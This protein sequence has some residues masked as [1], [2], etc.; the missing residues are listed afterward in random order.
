VR[1][2]FA[3]DQKERGGGEQGEEVERVSM[4]G[5]AERQF[6]THKARS[7]FLSLSLCIPHSAGLC[8]PT[9]TKQEQTKGGEW[10]SPL[11]CLF[12]LRCFNGQ[13]KIT[14]HLCWSFASHQ[15]IV[16]GQ[17]SSHTPNSLPQFGHPK[18]LSRHVQHQSTNKEQTDGST[19]SAL[20]VLFPLS[21]GG[22]MVLVVV[23]PSPYRR[24]RY[25]VRPR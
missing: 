11:T 20:F 8:C 10:K 6:T 22:V 7:L 14:Q 12:A 25:T 19:V 13:Q 18:K 3:R 1:N 16:F 4:S 23:T 9:K 15:L 2:R 21:L 5:R 24:F 17:K